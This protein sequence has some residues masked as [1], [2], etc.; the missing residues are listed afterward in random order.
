V[1]YSYNVLNLDDGT[2]LEYF[3]NPRAGLGV[4]WH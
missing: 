4:E 2:V 1:D 3:R